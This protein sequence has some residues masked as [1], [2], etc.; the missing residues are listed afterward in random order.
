M[1]KVGQLSFFST[2]VT[3]LYLKPADMKEGYKESKQTE[4]KSKQ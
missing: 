3:P 1:A 2:T 4:L